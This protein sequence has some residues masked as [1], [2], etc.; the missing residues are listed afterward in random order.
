[1]P[2]EVPAEA[3]EV[4]HRAMDKKSVVVLKEVTG[5]AGKDEIESVSEDNDS[6]SDNVGTPSL[7]PDLRHH[8]IDL[9]FGTEKQDLQT[10][11][12]T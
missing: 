9:Y 7:S 10:R 6:S 4:N 1:M 11:K 5:M 3:P 8:A 2:N 12:I